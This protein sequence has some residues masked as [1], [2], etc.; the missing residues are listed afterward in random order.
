MMV[1]RNQKV[2]G[3]KDKE[4]KKENKKKGS[5][6]NGNSFTVLQNDTQE[7][8]KHSQTREAE[9]TTPNS[10][11]IPASSIEKGK[12]IVT[13]ENLSHNSF[14]YLQ[15]LEGL[16]ETPIWVEGTNRMATSKGVGG[17]MKLRLSKCKKDGG[18]VS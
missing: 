2:E 14:S 6:N 15:G 18:M 7:E 1:G 11:L 8:E 13:G 3:L 10:G 5:G 9:T 16:H 4:R 17:N 12:N